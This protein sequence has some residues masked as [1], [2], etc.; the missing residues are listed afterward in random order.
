MRHTL[1]ND[2]PADGLPTATCSVT[3]PW[4][5]PFTAT[6]APSV[7]TS[8]CRRRVRRPRRRRADRRA[9]SVQP[10]PRAHDVVHTVRCH[11]GDHVGACTR[12]CP[13]AL[14]AGRH[15]SRL[16]RRLGAVAG[17]AE[18]LVQ[19]HHEVVTIL[20]ALPAGWPSGNAR[21]LR[22]RGGDAVDLEWRDGVLSS[23]VLHALA[24]REVT[25]DVPG[26]GQVRIKRRVSLQAGETVVVAP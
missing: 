11:V 21:G 26:D 5:P 25:I 10:A 22:V 9:A 18:L 16:L 7:S 15:A 20:P 19:S 24:T 12:E 14:R 3:V 4:A 23:V 8:T 6:R 17:I 2:V 1:Q 13:A